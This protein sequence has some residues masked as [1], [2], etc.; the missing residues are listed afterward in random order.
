MDGLQ[1]LR[2]ITYLTPGIPLSFYEAVAD[3]LQDTLKTKTS[4]GIVKGCS[5]PTTVGRDPLSKREADLAFLSAPSYLWLKNIKPSPVELLGAAPIFDD[6][7]LGKK[8]GAM[9]EVV[10]AN[11]GSFNSFEDLEGCLWAYTDLQAL[12]GYYAILRKMEEMKVEHFFSGNL[13]SGSHT[14]SID[15]VL[16]GEVD[17]AAIDSNVLSVQ[18]RSRPELRD[19]LQVLDSLGPFPVQP[20]VVRAGLSREVR[21]AIENALLGLGKTAKGKAIAQ[22][23]GCLGFGAPN[24]EDYTSEKLLAHYGP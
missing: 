1:K 16:D 12:T 21:E 14:Q 9:C 22:H 18:M 11:D 3:Y 19:E 5:G 2:I 6:P 20:V 4:V 8:P 7:R 24:P 15:W 10:V 13:G 17:M 23:F